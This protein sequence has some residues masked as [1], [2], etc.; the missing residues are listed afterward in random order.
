MICHKAVFLD[1]DGTINE[2]VGD[3]DDPSKFRLI[4]KA[5]E[6][7][8][9]LQDHFCLFVITNQSG[10]GEGRFDEAGYS[11]VNDSFMAC[12]KEAGVRILEVRHCPHAK[13]DR[14]ICHKPSPYFIEK[15]CAKYEIDVRQSFCIGD[16]PH[17]IEMA[18]RCGARSVY[19]L[20]GH[21]AKHRGE[22]ISKPDH[23]ATDLYEAAVW[24]DRK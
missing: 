3:L 15:L 7:L 14:C 18:K 20:T 6:A 8:K 13:K 21:G 23:I 16:H 4:P 10:I 11:R 2:D 12:L 17:D 9:I 22:L 19:L 5:A 1:R 24:I